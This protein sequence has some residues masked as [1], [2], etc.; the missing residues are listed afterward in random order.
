MKRH[1]NGWGFFGAAVLACCSVMVSACAKP[2]PPERTV[3]VSQC[4]KDGN[5]EEACRCMA[6]QAEATLDKEVLA[7]MALAAEGKDD[8]ADEA[9]R[10]LTMEQQFSVAP[11]AAAAVEACNLS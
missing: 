9:M 10:K 8:E 11:F 3:L 2:E 5:T 4:V 1:S 7:A 6:D